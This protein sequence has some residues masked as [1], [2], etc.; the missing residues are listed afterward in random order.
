MPNNAS[1][2]NSKEVISAG[3]NCICSTARGLP[4]YCSDSLKEI[5]SLTDKHFLKTK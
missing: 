3:F 1:E 5:T 2:I 4:L